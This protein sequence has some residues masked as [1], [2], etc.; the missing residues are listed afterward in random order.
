[1]TNLV[2]G[3]KLV[4]MGKKVL[5]TGGAGFIGSHI[6]D[7]FIENNYNVVIVDDLSSGREK[8]I[9][10]KAQFYKLNVADQKGLSQVFKQEKP[11]YVC[12][13][14]AQISV[15]FSVRDPSNWSNFHT[16]PAF[17]P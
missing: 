17:S 7:L 3:T 10:K 1:M 13:E 12:H 9:N 11:D 6:V 4:I 8:N 2:P 15:S 5:V 16:L 14:A